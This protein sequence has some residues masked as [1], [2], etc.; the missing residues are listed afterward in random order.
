MKTVTILGLS[1]LVAQS[2]GP[3][4]AGQAPAEDATRLTYHRVTSRES[5]VADPGGERQIIPSLVEGL[6]SPEDWYRKRR[7][8]LLALWT[9]ILGKLGPDRR[10]RRW[11][12]DIRRARILETRELD[13]YTR[14]R[15]DLPIEKDFYQKHLLL[16]P[17]NQGPGPFPAVV[18]W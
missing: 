15:L 3:T 4:R 8:E 7:P 18:C 13:A 12:G 9:R 16:I 1:L 2:A 5:P 11:F 10:D 6:T 14:I 17:R